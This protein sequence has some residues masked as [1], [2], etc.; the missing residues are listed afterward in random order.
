MFWLLA[1]DDEPSSYALDRMIDVHSL[2]PYDW[3]LR[4]IDWLNFQIDMVV[5]GYQLSRPAWL[6]DSERLW[7]LVE[8]EEAVKECIRLHNAC[9][10][11]A[12]HVGND[13]EG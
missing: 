8:Y 6:N 12:D 7:A 10:D 1:D 9:F 13:F 2:A 5:E 3:I 4:M 11:Y